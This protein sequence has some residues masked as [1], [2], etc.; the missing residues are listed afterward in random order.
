MTTDVRVLTEADATAYQAL[1]LRSLQEHPEAFGSAYD[2]EVGR[3]L[4]TIQQRLR[5]TADHFALGAWRGADLVGIV[6]FG[7]S[8]GVKI[9]HRG[10]IG[11][12]YV[13]AEARGEGVGKAL[14]AELIRRARLMAGLE[15][16]ILAVTVG[17]G[18]ARSIYLAAGF[19]PSHVE[20]RYIKVADRY[21]D[22]EWMTLCLK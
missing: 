2:D 14:L 15:E 19:E 12:M 9:R 8:P 13:A 1:R 20:K 4:E 11:G 3:P 17:N 16:I 22:I 7:R 6:A 10:G 21:Y 18:A 5:T